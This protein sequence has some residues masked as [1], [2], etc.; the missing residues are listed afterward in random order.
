[1]GIQLKL[2]VLI[3]LTVGL[4]TLTLTSHF[5]RG[6]VNALNETRLRKA[7]TY[8]ALVAAQVR[9]AVAFDDVE[10]A[11]E[12][13]DSLVQDPMV[14]AVALFTQNGNLLHSYGN[15]GEAA[16][17]ARQGVATTRRFTLEDSV[18]V[19]TPVISVEGPR[20]T[21]V[22]QLST[23]DVSQSKRS[24][25][26]SAA[27]IGGG[28]FL[29]GA[30]VA[31]LIAR[32]FARR[33][34]AV[35]AVAAEV[36]E[37]RLEQQPLNDP[38]RDEI[39]V[40]ANG[41]DLMT[42]RLR[43]LIADMALRAQQE[44]ERLETEVASRTA[45]LQARN[46]DMRRV[47]DQ[48]G[49]GFLSVDVDGRMSSEHSAILETWFGDPRAHSSLWSYLDGVAPGSGAAFRANWEQV[50]AGV[51]PLELSLAQMPQELVVAEQ[52]FS[53]DYQPIGRRGDSFERMFIVISDVTARVQRRRAEAD[54]REM[55]QLCSA[56]MRDREGVLEF[57][58]E[59]RQQ[60]ECLS[61]SASTSE[62]ILRAAH[63]LKGN[64]A[65]FGMSS[66]AQLCHAAE[67]AVQDDAGHLLASIQQRL[68]QCFE[69]VASRLEALIGSHSARRFVLLEDDL[70]D[71]L[72]AV[73]QG[74]APE[75]LRDRIAALRLEPAEQRLQRVARQVR[76][77][78]ERLGKGKVDVHV[79]HG[80]LRLDSARLKGFWAAFT[81]AVRN[82]VDHGLQDA[83]QRAAAGKTPAARIALRTAIVRGELQIE[84]EDDGGAIDWAVVRE[85]ARARGL[86]CDTPEQLSAA[87]FT[88]GF[89][90]KG[91]VSDTSGRGV[92]LSALHEVCTRLGGKV[93]ITSQRSRF[94]RLTCRLPATLAAALDVQS[95]QHAHGKSYDKHSPFASAQAGG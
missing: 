50:I 88:P 57:L 93:L 85:L 77:L 67:T 68:Q 78:G 65:L 31:F 74:I 11:R 53:I 27:L 60:L 15:L 32:S 91:A 90:T 72:R 62:E 70:E 81:H 79:D 3:L 30:L 61:S 75:A 38:S 29:I 39:G 28:V 4:A 80:R 36:S 5:L 71:L 14:E 1:M 92:G 45:Q 66:V 13:F 54:E 20:G 82:A 21:L 23:A 25:Q 41:V 56:L 89:S 16:F 59:A 58:S 17:A 76:G 7:D 49:Q 63:T 24:M 33:L 84:I 9:S 8:A 40:L 10:T 43:A 73:E 44:Q 12:V 52:H 37:G 46:E 48:V 64:A 55:A 87:L 22:L 6:Q 69:H 26:L 19:V 94:T 95:T 18:L 2:L 47:L 35:A 86:A 51:L 42:Q 83:D 34:R